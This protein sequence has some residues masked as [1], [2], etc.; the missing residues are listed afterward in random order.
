MSVV[1]FATQL[2]SLAST[3]VPSK[4]PI[5]VTDDVTMVRLEAPD[6]S[7]PSPSVAHFSPDG[8]HFAIVIRKAN[9][10]N[11]ASESSLL[12]YQ[13][14]ESLHVPKPDVLLRMSST[15]NSEAIRK[16]RWLAD[17]ETLVFLGENPGEVSQI[18]SFNIRA[19]RLKKL[20][21]HP[22]AIANYD[23]TQDGQETV[24]VADPPEQEASQPGQNSK[25]I[26]V[27]NQR[28]VEILTGNYSQPRQMFWR[29][30]EEAP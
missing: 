20:T 5:T 17:S 13:T 15:S 16:V 7:V 6:Y 29:A 22:T 27:T 10:E 24:F 21:S 30:G 26:V 8:S 23:M 14:S 11:D 3:Q 1:G 4:R 28:F 12:L 9:V 25:E 19:R 2:Q 18:Y